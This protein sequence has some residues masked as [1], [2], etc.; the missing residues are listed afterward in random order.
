MLSDALSSSSTS[1]EKPYSKKF[2]LIGSLIA[3][4]TLESRKITSLD[5]VLIINNLS[6]YT[7]SI[8]TLLKLNKYSTHSYY[9]SEALYISLISF[10]QA[11]NQ[12]APLSICDCVLPLPLRLLRFFS[13]ILLEAFQ[14]SQNIVSTAS[15]LSVTFLSDQSWV[16]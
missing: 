9:C 7:P 16:L 5:L 10:Y 8:F 14:K 11:G 13:K 3:F 12:P 4:I 2:R 6:H 1:T 15:L